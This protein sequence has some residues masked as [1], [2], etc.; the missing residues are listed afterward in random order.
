MAAVSVKRS[1]H[2]LTESLR[3]LSKGQKYIFA[4]FEQDV[5]FGLP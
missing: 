3:L 1:I 2:L 5:I 4:S